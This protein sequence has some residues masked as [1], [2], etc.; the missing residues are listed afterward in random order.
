MK[1]WVKT[2]GL[3]TSKIVFFLNLSN[4]FSRFLKTINCNNF[5]CNAEAKHKD[6]GCIAFKVWKIKLEV[7]DNY[8]S[9]LE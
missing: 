6:D 5:S 2:I 8:S 4:F 7:I 3:C 1:I 9:L